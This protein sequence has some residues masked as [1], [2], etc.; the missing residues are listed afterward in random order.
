MGKGKLH[1][2]IVDSCLLQPPKGAEG[3]NVGG[4][5]MPTLLATFNCNTFG[6]PQVTLY[7]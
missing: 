1:I 7:D 5:A 2:V 3:G 6:N 4:Q